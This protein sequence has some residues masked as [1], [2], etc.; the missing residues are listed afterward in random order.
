MYQIIY[1]SS[2]QTPFTAEDLAELLRKARDKN[3]MLKVTGLLLYKDGN[4]IQVLEGQEGT[5]KQLYATIEQDFRHHSII[6]LSE[7]TIPAREFGDWAMGFTDI[8]ALTEADRPGLST[9]LA[10]SMT[11]ETLAKT[12]SRARVLLETFRKNMR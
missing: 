7:A 1:V 9:F 3:R 4:F 2:A 11:P 8:A 5:V 10:E 6:K 12:P